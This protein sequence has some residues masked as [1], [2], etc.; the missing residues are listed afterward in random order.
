MQPIRSPVGRGGGMKSFLIL[1]A[2]LAT[3]W[4]LMTVH[5]LGAAQ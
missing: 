3:G 1:F 4:I 5:L 2:I